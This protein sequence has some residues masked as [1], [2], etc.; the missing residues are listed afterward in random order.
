MKK[1]LLGALFG[2]VMAASASAAT[3]FSD[4]FS[5]YG[6][7]SQVPAGANFLGPNWSSTPTV[8]YLAGADTGNFGGLCQGTGNCVDLDGT[9]NPFSAGLLSTVMSFGPGSYNLSI[10][11][12]GSGRG[13]TEEVTISLGDWSTTISNIASSDNLMLELVANTTASG[14]LSFQNSGDDNVGAVLTSASVSAVPIPA[15]GLLLLAGVGGLAALRHR[16]K[17]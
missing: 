11:L 1:I 8:D 2:S 3:L 9:T 7:V 6:D 4:D 10:H 17:G 5:S 13:S 12:L 16:K 15:T 14:S